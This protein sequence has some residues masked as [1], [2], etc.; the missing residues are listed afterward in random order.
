MGPYGQDETGLDIYNYYFCLF[1][2]K[3]RLLELPGLLEKADGKNMGSVYF[4][5]Y[6]ALEQLST[7]LPGKLIMPNAP[8]H[9]PGWG[10]L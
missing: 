9:P 4:V 1:T 5:S 3:K 10:S 6:S 7:F 2:F 8:S